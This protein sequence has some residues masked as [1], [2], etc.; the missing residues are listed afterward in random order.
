MEVTITKDTAELERL[1]GIITKNLQSFYEVG[2]ALMEIRDKRLYEKVR[3]TA[4]FETYCRERWDFSRIRAFQ[5]IQF[6]EVRDNLLTVVN[7]QPT[8]EFQTRPLARLEP[9][10]QREAWQQAVATAPDGKVTA[11]HVYKIVKGMREPEAKPAPKPP[12]PKIPEHAIYLAIIA[13]S[14]LERISDDDP[15]R[16]EAL[17]KVQN[18]INQ[19]RGGGKKK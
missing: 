14:Q 17:D 19:H 1:E 10:Q 4:T 18:W 12:Q 3:G 5:L 9:T 16:D 15:T 8:S 2:H 7:I 13:I 6:V 11:A